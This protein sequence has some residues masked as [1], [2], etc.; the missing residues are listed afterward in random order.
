MREV[1]PSLRPPTETRS[2]SQPTKKTEKETRPRSRDGD[3]G[4]CEEMHKE[5]GESINSRTSAN[6][7]DN[8]R[9]GSDGRKQ[10]K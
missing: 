4:G 3:D 1:V 6:G 10:R 9:R 5:N 8:A 7:T 2:A